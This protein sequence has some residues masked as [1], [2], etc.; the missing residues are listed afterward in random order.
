MLVNL[1][2]IATENLT[3]IELIVAEIEMLT[4]R[5][6]YVGNCMHDYVE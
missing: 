2:R 3:K 4:R 1:M 6:A 5:V